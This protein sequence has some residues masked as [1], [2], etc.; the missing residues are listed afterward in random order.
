MPQVKKVD[1]MERN[2][3]F[4]LIVICFVLSY[5]FLFNGYIK[6]GLIS[7]LFILG[8]TLVSI[9]T[10]YKWLYIATMIGLISG[11]CMGISTFISFGSYS[12][13][14]GLMQGCNI[15]ALVLWGFVSCLRKKIYY[16]LKSVCFICL[17]AIIV[18]A[19][20]AVSVPSQ[21]LYIV[22]D[23][24]SVSF[25]RL[26]MISLCIQIVLPVVIIYYAVTK[27]ISYTYKRKLMH[28]YNHQLVKSR[29]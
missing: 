8:L 23:T 9:K 5:C 1:I 3:V 13:L 14:L 6:A 10:S 25:I 22:S 11:F 20:L 24:V 27:I 29:A 4:D 16:Q 28:S 12:Y 15:V 21:W 17:I 2:Y 19:L 7:S 26:M 18:M